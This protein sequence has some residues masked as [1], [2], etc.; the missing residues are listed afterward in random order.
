MQIACVKQTILCWHNVILQQ[1]YSWSDRF[2][3]GLPSRWRSA[4]GLKTQAICQKDP[5][6]LWW[7]LWCMN[8]LCGIPLWC[9]GIVMYELVAWYPIVMY[10]NCD[11]WIGCVVTWR[12]VGEA[13][14]DIVN[15]CNTT[16]ARSRQKSV[17][18]HRLSVFG[19]RII[20]F[21]WRIFIFGQR[22]WVQPDF[23]ECHHHNG[24]PERDTS[25]RAS[26]SVI[27]RNHL[28][29]MN[30]YTWHLIII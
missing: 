9:M 23:W 19:R 11:V 18:Q 7:E 30:I 12:M 17:L 20:I 5:S 26:E 3:P 13:C 28:G 14:V 8:W 1:T 29:L 27:M 24:I 2:C 22:L 15:V 21:Y 10:G 4:R 25:F 16:S 6:K